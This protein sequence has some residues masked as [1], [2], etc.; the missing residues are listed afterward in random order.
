M[1]VCDV[2]KKTAKE[3]YLTTLYLKDPNKWCLEYGILENL[4]EH[5][6]GFYKECKKISENFWESEKELK[7]IVESKKIVENHCN[8]QNPKAQL[9]SH[10]LQIEENEILR[11]ICDKLL[12]LDFEVDVLV[13]DGCMVRK[14]DKNIKEALN[15]CETSVFDNTGYDIDL[16]VK[17]MN[18]P[19][20]LEEDDFDIDDFEIPEERKMKWDKQYLLSLKTK[21]PSNTYLM[22]KKY[23]ECFSA[24]VLRPKPMYVVYEPTEPDIDICTDSDMKERLKGIPSGIKNIAQN[25]LDNVK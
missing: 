7:K 5:I 14:C 13:F 12:E 20:Q 25:T 22:R 6:I 3:L 1:K 10:Y 17:E 8:R 24:K 16:L 18:D 19:I 11:I 9:L 4:P 15:E 23:I 2:G 21:K